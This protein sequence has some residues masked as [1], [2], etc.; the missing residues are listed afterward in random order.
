MFLYLSQFR[1]ILS[2]DLVDLIVIH[3]GGFLIDS[4]VGFLLLFKLTRPLGYLFT[5]LFNSMNSQIFSIGMFPY[6]MLCVLPI[7]SS[8]DW[9]KSL[10]RLFNHQTDSPIEVDCLE[11]EDAKKKQAK[12]EVNEKLE[13]EDKVKKNEREGG[14]RRGKNEVRKG[15]TPTENKLF[16]LRPIG[17]QSS[18]KEEIKV[19]NRQRLT[20]SLLLIYM[21]LQVG[22]PFSHDLTQGY[23]TW[24]QGVYGY[25]WDMMVHNWR[26]LGK[27]VLIVDKRSGRE[28]YLN[29]E[30]YSPNNRWTHHADM[31]KQ[32]AECL[33]HR[34]KKMTNLTDFEIRM[35]V[36]MS[37][38][39]R[40]A[41]RVFDPTVDLL[42]AE[43]SPFKKPP[44]VLP[45]LTQF[46]DWRSILKE[47]E[48]NILN[49]NQSLYVVFM[50][51]FPGN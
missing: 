43:W 25:S 46:T 21:S 32:F 40:F 26:L 3:W 50:A 39:K 33:G 16:S 45:M 6:V 14:K 23:N 5:G 29:V 4:S 48:E 36:W 1:L 24:T 15:T 2:P 49:S 41:Q 18:S 30:K 13:D 44:W 37:L 17:L 22:L 27:R 47:Y 12:G 11:D 7:Y 19:T 34:I 20:C 42:A 31:A 51:D 9:P 38:N 35:D 10:I 28:V 8:P